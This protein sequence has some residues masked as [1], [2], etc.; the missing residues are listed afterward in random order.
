[1]KMLLPVLALLLV[2]ITFSA[3]ASIA[4][5][6]VEL[7]VDEGRTVCSLSDN[8]PAVVSLHVFLTGPD[9][10]TLVGF[11]ATLPDCWQGATWLADVTPYVS[12]GTSQGEMSVAFGQCLTPPVHAVEIQVATSGT[13]LPC[14]EVKI[15]QPISF[16]LQ[17]VDCGFAE[18]NATAGQSVMVNPNASCPCTTP[19]AT[20]SSTWGRVK[21][22]YR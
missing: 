10:A 3:T 1:M 14:C 13:S 16:P 12:I 17:I 22:L 2:S 6:K 15:L 11:K 19:V 8:V 7:F 4:Q 9:N 20:E 18:V 5:D 21:A